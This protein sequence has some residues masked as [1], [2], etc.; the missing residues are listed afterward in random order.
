MIT[1]VPIGGLGNRMRA[2]ASGIALSRATNQQLRVFWIKDK[3]LNCRFDE[4]FCY[5]KINNLVIKEHSFWNKFAIDYPRK[6][7]A[8]LPK[9]F[10][11]LL[12]DGRLYGKESTKD[13]MD[14]PS[15]VLHYRHP[16]IAS[17]SP[18]F[19]ATEVKWQD[20][21]KP[22]R[23]LDEKVKSNFHSFNA[24]TV[25]VHIRRSD[26]VQSI[27]E[28]PIELFVEAIQKELESCPETT[29][30]VCS[31]SME[32]KKILSE[33][34]NKNIILS[35]E[36][37]SRDNET[38]IKGALVDLFTLAGCD[39]IFGSYYSSFSEIAALL[40]NKPLKIIRKHK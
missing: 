40:G 5:P 14:F 15:W 35:S 16:Y 17:F 30:F 23:E 8:Y 24:H 7:N 21:F 6:S 18:F 36:K 26:N 37:G 22:K 28:S 13:A 34:F 32:V 4:L 31:D 27:Q 39:K 38:G 25:G 19:D 20:V 33:K 10:H 9:F 11:P 3:G 2:F 29:F 1:L 12:F